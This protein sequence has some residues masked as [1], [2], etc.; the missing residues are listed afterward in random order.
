LNIS[1]EW[2]KIQDDRSLASLARLNKTAIL[3]QRTIIIVKTELAALEY[4]TT[5]QDVETKMIED[6]D[7]AQKL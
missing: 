5:K 6:S 2:A 3:K 4:V 7:I 1:Q